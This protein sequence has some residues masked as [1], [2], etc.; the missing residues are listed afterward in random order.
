MPYEEALNN[1][2]IL[3]G[4]ENIW[5]SIDETRARG[6][7]VGLRHY[8]INRKVACSNP[9]EV[10]GFL[11][12]PNPSSLNK[13]LVSTQPPTEMSTRNIP[14]GKGRQVLKADNLSVIC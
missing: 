7:V 13:A 5:V 8:A 6:S 12:W 11:N 14:A 4:K 9:D 10:T 1:V 3:L 2:W